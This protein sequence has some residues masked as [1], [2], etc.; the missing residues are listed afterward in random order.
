MMVC[1]LLHDFDDRNADI[2]AERLAVVV[3]IVGNVL[4]STADQLD[5]K[6]S[7]ISEEFVA[8]AEFKVTAHA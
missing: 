8:V 6:G 5:C 4:T 7:W 2:W 3:R 1:R